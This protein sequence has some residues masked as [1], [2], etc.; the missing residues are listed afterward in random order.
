VP[1]DASEPEVSGLM[2]WVPVA[3]DL[4][5]RAARAYPVMQP[6]CARDIPTRS[7]Q[8][9]NYYC[10]YAYDCDYAS[11]LLVGYCYDVDA[12]VCVTTIASSL[13][14]AS[15]LSEA[16]DLLYASSYAAYKLVRVAFFCCR[17]PLMLYP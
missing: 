9:V 14:L 4:V 16:I 6:P 1:Y 17:V 15:P 12:S 2:S 3:R 5:R 8:F 11:L 7:K 10:T 13:L